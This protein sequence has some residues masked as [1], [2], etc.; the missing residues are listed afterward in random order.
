MLLKIGEKNGRICMLIQ[1]EGFKK[2]YTASHFNFL[3]S[4][5]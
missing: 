5:I 3:P 1:N 4:D 2:Y